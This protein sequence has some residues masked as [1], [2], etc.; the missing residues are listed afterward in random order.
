MALNDTER[1]WARYGGLVLRGVA[2]LLRV[3][4]TSWKRSVERNKEVGGSPTSLHLNGG[5][6]DFSMNTPDWKRE[7]LQL[8]CAGR[9]E[10]GVHQKGTAEHWHLTANALTVLKGLGVLV[11][12]H[13]VFFKILRG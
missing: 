5:A 3:N 4:V 6:I 2:G 13:Y 8:F 9:S 10:D 11:V 7:I 1:L 12:A